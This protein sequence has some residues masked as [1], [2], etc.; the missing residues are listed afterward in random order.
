MEF[1][2]AAI[3]AASHAVDGAQVIRKLTGAQRGEVLEDLH[4]MFKM[5]KSQQRNHEFQQVAGQMGVTSS[6]SGD[7]TDA[8]GFEETGV[9]PSDSTDVLDADVTSLTDAG[10]GGVLE[11]VGDVVSDIVDW[12]SDLF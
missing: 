3:K 6:D 12:I 5:G 2:N 7:G 4:N 9:M 10:D 1:I 8:T 11:A